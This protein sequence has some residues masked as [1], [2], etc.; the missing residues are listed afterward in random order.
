MFNYLLRRVI[1]I[2]PVLFLITLS[3]FLLGDVIPGNFADN[4]LDLDDPR[5]AV[6]ENQQA[7]R[8]SFQEMRTR[9]RLDLPVFYLQFG[10]MAECDTLARVPAA[11]HQRWLR[12]LSFE[13]GNWQAISDL[14]AEVLAIRDHLDEQVQDQSAYLPAYLDWQ[15][16]L[17]QHHLDEISAHLGF[18]RQKAQTLND[19]VLVQCTS[20]AEARLTALAEAPAH[21]KKY[22]P[23]LTWAG[24]QNRYHQWLAGLFRFDFGQSEVDQ[25]PVAPKVGRALS[26]TLSLTIVTI[27]LLFAAA[28]PL[29]MSLGKKVP[30]LSKRV[31][32][33][34]LVGLDAV[35]LFLLCVLAITFFA[36]REFLRLFP[37]YG[38]GNT[39]LPGLGWY[40][41]FSIRIY[42]LAL[43]VLCM[44]LAS[45]PYVSKQIEGSVRLVYGQLLIIAARARGLSEKK[46]QWKHALSAVIFPIITLISGYLPAAVSGALVVEVIFSIPGMG[47][48][49]ADAVLARDFPVI[50]AVVLLVA[51]VKIISNLL[52]DLAYFMTDPRVRYKA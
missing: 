28:I 17:L 22:I 43:P 6:A 8:R 30:Q 5:L 42:H 12:R 49:I 33:G 26:V 32:S 45:M 21:Y 37:T 34:I 47:K 10:T 11:T 15:E 7:M 35:P 48:L 19:P 50:M 20:R 25:R 27:I 52:A 46:I 38:L 13:Y 24:F 36:N 51:I 18:I 1:L 39:S 4:S 31:T 9:S 3:I 40:D 29:G 41:K 16:L 14:Y 2:L 23:T 44:I